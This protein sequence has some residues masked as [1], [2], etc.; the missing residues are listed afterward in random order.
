M[1]KK[2]KFLIDISNLRKFEINRLKKES[3]LEMRV[4]NE[5]AFDAKLL[6]KMTLLTNLR[7]NFPNVSSPYF[8]LNTS[9]LETLLVLELIVRRLIESVEDATTS[10]LSGLESL[11][12]LLKS[13]GAD[14]K[15]KS[16]HE[17]VEKQNLFS[18]LVR[19]K[20]SLI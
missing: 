16:R 5:E 7:K 14:D 3:L 4:R 13:K 12:W 15:L 8:K 11:S 6:I 19:K 2:S 9:T 17:K 10:L 18:D 1:F 20:F